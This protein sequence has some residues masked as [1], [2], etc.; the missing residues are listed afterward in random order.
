[1]PD[2]GLSLFPLRW[3]HEVLTAGPPGEAHV[4]EYFD[5]AF[6]ITRQVAPVNSPTIDC[7]SGQGEWQVRNNTA[8]GSVA[9]RGTPARGSQAQEV[10]NHGGR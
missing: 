8:H 10:R 7:N 3:K 1:M 6:V 9:V 2:R 4:L 5:S